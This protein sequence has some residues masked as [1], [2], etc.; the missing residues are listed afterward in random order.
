MIE[1]CDPKA[2]R[3]SQI[4]RA[5]DSDTACYR[6]LYQEKKKANVQFSIDQFCKKVGKMPSA[7]TSSQH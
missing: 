5:T 2:E 4:R 1:E 7:S 3:S 6:L